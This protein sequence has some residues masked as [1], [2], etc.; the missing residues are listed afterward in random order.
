MI[1]RFYYG[2]INLDTW[3]LHYINDLIISM[4]IYLYGQFREKNRSYLQTWKHSD[5]DVNSYRTHEPRINFKS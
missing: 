1:F 3:P 2:D 5:T 4:P